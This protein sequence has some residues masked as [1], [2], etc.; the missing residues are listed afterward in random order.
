ML[1]G[2]VPVIPTPYR[3]DGEVDCTAVKELVK[4][5]A[6]SG[7][8]GVLVSGSGGEMPYLSGEERVALVRAAAEAGEGLPVMC[9]V[10]AMSSKQAAQEIRGVISAGASYVLVAMPV[11]YSVRLSNALDYYRQAAEAS[12]GKTLYYHFPQ[13]TGFDPGPDAVAEICRLEGIIGAKMSRPNLKEI[14]EVFHKTDKRDFALFS[15]TILLMEETMKLGGV[16]VIGILP[17]VFPEESVQWYNAVKSGDEAQRKFYAEKVKKAVNLLAGFTAPPFLQ[18][19]GLKLLSRLPFVLSVGEHSH[20]ACVKEALRL[21]GF[22][23][24]PIVRSPLP[25][26]DEQTKYK[27]GKLMRKLGAAVVA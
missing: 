18:I 6:K 7:C 25:A 21:R 4:W 23:I 9:G 13:A 16:G 14:E 24:K 27:V 5:Y 15:G 19:S 1:S 12:M 26:L 17:A 22:P 11:Y 20:H 10:G 3:D 8:H 2:V